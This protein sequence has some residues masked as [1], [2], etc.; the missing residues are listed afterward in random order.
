MEICKRISKH[1][2]TIRTGLVELPI[3]K[4][5]LA[6]AH[7]ISQLK[8]RIIDSVPIQRRGGDRQAILKERE[9]MW[10]HS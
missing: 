1:N 2:S 9:L 3:P 4:H 5:F 10:I 7:S 8:F 6:Q